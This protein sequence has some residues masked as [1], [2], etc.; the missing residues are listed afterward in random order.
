MVFFDLSGQTRLAA[1][2]GQA[3]PSAEGERQR[4]V[5]SG[6]VSAGILRDRF[7]YPV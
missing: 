2:N 6:E 5:D 4:E 1:V 3:A 7:T